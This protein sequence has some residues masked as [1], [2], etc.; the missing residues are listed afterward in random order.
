[1]T[2]EKPLRTTALRYAFNA[3]EHELLH[4]Y[5]IPGLRRNRQKDSPKAETHLKPATIHD[6]Y[7]A[8]TVRSSVRVFIGTTAGL[9]VWELISTF[10][11]I[12]GTSQR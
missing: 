9:K 7:H 6:D 11:L 4:R 12:R 5:L 3:H 2:S 1:M 8:A 10:L